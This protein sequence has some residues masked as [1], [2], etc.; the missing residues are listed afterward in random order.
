MSEE[1]ERL[2]EGT[3]VSHLL[4]LRDRLLRAFIAVIIVFVPCAIYSNELFTFLAQPLLEKLPKGATLIATSVISP[5]M[6]PF[7]L[8]F[9]VALYFAMP[10]V[11]YQIWAFIAPG[12]YRRERRF[13]LPLLVSSILL[14]YVGTAFAYFA[15]FPVMFEFFTKTT[16]AGV[17]MMTDI[18]SYM[19]FVL[20]MFFAFGV[21]FEMPVAVVLAVLAGL[22]TVEKLVQAR[23]YVLIGIFVVAAF[24]TPPDAISQCIMAIPMYLLY[25]GGLVMAR[26]MQKVRRA[27]ARQD[28]AD[29]P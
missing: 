25:E 26:I 23:G 11:L 5:F 22:V 19:D 18:S 14:F 17:T 1:P 21:A 10:V 24:L 12:L 4:E 7:K 20:T 27:D 3:L 8:A 2:A 29:S 15:V 13:G 16:P 6:T 9:F 28:S